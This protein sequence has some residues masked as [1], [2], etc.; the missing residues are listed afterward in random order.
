MNKSSS[1]VEQVK[2]RDTQILKGLAAKNN[3]SYI[4]FGEEIG[5]RSAKS[6]GKL[7]LSDAF[8]TALQPAPLTPTVKD[9]APYQLL[10]GTIKATYDAHRDGDGVIVS[11]GIMSGNTGMPSSPNNSDAPN[12]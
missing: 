3:L 10:S 8:N 9:A 1:S 5:D 11:P 2:E 4:A 12:N 6:Y 7:T